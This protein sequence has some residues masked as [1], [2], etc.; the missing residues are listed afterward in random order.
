MSLTEQRPRSISRIIDA[1]KRRFN[2][3]SEE[4]RAEMSD[5]AFEQLNG[6][7]THSV[8]QAWNHGFT[9]TRISEPNDPTPHQA[10]Q[11]DLR[12]SHSN[13][14]FWNRW[15]TRGV[16]GKPGFTEEEFLIADT[17]INPNFRRRLRISVVTTNDGDQR[18]PEIDYYKGDKRQRSADAA[19]FLRQ[20]NN[21][22]ADRTATQK[23]RE[24]IEKEAAADRTS[25]FDIEDTFHSMPPKPNIVIQ[26][27]TPWK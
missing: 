13:R 17:H 8:D 1:A 11:V 6:A 12:D 24:Q 15:I 25:S 5:E 2:R 26:P 9:T 7:I 18:V 4:R 21:T 22:V 23:R 3:Q 19:E 10:T 27:W 16:V 20:T 14:T